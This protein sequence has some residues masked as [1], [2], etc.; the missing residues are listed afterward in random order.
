MELK[1][2]AS[3]VE[4]EL[5][6]GDLKQRPLDLHPFGDDDVFER[7]QRPPPFKAQMKAELI[8]IS[9][10]WLI[11]VRRN[12]DCHRSC[13]RVNDHQVIRPSR[14][15][16]GTRVFRSIFAGKFVVSH[17]PDATPTRPRI[18]TC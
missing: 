9:R 16:R 8:G 1:G 14:R 10:R 5:N 13:R 18:A 3:D 12:L 15:V 7:Q 17:C 2:A 6:I 11:K 4:G